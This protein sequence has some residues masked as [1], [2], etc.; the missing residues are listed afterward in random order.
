MKQENWYDDPDYKKIE[1]EELKAEKLRKSEEFAAEKKEKENQFLPSPK[2]GQTKKYNGTVEL[3]RDTYGPEA[4][5]YLSGG[6]LCGWANQADKEAKYLSNDLAHLNGCEVE[7]IVRVLSAPK[8]INK[9]PV[10][11]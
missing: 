1:D 7:V 2:I 10:Y 6:M 5:V 3:W 11:G 4:D 9:I 8:K